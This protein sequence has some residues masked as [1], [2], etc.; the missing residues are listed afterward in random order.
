M[1]RR[2]IIKLQKG[3]V[4]M[5]NMREVVSNYKRIF[6]PVLM[7]CFTLMFLPA[8]KVKAASVFWT[9]PGNFTPGWYQNGF[10]CYGNDGTE[11][12]PY[13]ICSEEDLAA[14]SYYAN[15]SQ[16]QGGSDFSGKYI[17]ITE[18]E[19]DMSDYE[20][21][22]IGN[23]SYF[24]GKLMGNQ[25]TI[26]N[27]ILGG[28]GY[29]QDYT[30]SGFFGLFGG[31]AKDIA[32]QR[33]RYSFDGN[34]NP[35]IIGGFAAVDE[36]VIEGCK[37]QGEIT[38][39]NTINDVTG[40]FVGDAE[41][42]N[43]IN[44]CSCKVNL[45]I[46]ENQSPV[47]ALGGFAGISNGQ[48]DNSSYDGTILLDRDELAYAGGFT[49]YGCGGVST[50]NCQVYTNIKLISDNRIRYL[51]GFI[52]MDP[53]VIQNSSAEVELNTDFYN[54]LD[55]L[56]GFA[57]CNENNSVYDSCSAQISL[58]MINVVGKYTGGFAGAGCTGDFYN[59][60][61]SGNILT[62]LMDHVGGFAGNLY[63]TNVNHCKSET[64]VSDTS[65]AG[66]NGAATG[67]FA[68][69]ISESTIDACF[70]KGKVKAGSNVN[71]G[72]FCGYADNSDII[73]C[74]A[75]G[76][77]TTGSS[78][79]VGGFI[80]VCGRARICASYNSCKISA[81]SQ[82]NLGGAIGYDGG[83]NQITNLYWCRDKQQILAGVVRPT[84]QNLD[85]GNGGYI[86]NIIGVADSMM[87]SSIFQGF[88]NSS[89]GSVAWQ[90]N[91]AV[92]SG[93]PY[94]S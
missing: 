32:L 35:K 38:L 23:A 90:Q 36:G 12:N 56:G 51:G 46:I 5:R 79:N 25:T 80:G 69:L 31:T 7:F 74:Y 3:G 77:I 42:Q 61:T 39:R 1:L 15:I 34:C 13:L 45:Y 75:L 8:I 49:G 28:F 66:D 68:A 93:Y 88:L 20:W 26:R 60:K 53:G 76:T 54:E 64:T 59:C 72:G 21:V 52:G 55:Y 43:G 62:G 9:D 47:K 84:N 18:T 87:K 27:I 89:G 57:G 91:P 65:I 50:D 71:V 10:D 67:G 78:C 73:S 29:P 63:R 14:L 11:S 22:P 44:D 70:S 24:R 37:V 85:I 92:N 86:A 81:G 2:S 94:F 4:F 41:L 58:N 19:L 82:S 40:G 48:M 16:S 30:F 6:L 83:N 17:S 33:I